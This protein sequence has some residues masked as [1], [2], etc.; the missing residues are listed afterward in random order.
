MSGELSETGTKNIGAI[1]YDLTRKHGTEKFLA[2]V[3]Y[4]VAVPWA[5]EVSMNTDEGGV[6]IKRGDEY[7]KQRLGTSYDLLCYDGDCRAQNGAGANCWVYLEDEIAGNTADAVMVPGKLYMIYLTE[8]TS[9]I[10]FKKADD[11]SPIHTNTLTVSAY[12]ETTP[13][14]GKDANWNGIANPATYRAYMGVSVSEGGLVQKFVPGTKPR[15]PGSYLTL[16]LNDKQAVGQPFFVQVDPTAGTTVVANRTNPSTVSA[17]YAQEPQE[18]RYAIGVAANGKL[19]DRLYIQTAEEKEDKYVIG[20]DMSKMGVS[21]YV[22]QMWVN[23]YDSKLCQNTVAWTRNKAD[24]PIG[25][26]APQAGEYM[27]FAPA[28]IASGDNIYLTLDGRVIWNLTYSPYYASLEQGTTTRYGLRIVR[29]N[30]SGGT[31]GVDE[32]H[33]VDI[34]CEKVIMDDHVYILRGEELYTVTGQKAK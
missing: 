3:W 11:D 29:D 6:Y 34:Q 33:S 15:D 31:T 12:E 28:E 30:T 18:A 17:R 14:D 4:A 23:R 7:V 16:N 26:S 24:Y 13:N 1:Y 27:I 22:A 10:R 20:K 8:E 21:T 5:V 9:T 32:V 2:R 19:A 25:I